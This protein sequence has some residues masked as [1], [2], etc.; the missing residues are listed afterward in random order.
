MGMPVGIK[1]A[2]RW[3]AWCASAMAALAL[4]MGVHKAASGYEDRELPRGLSHPIFA[5]QLA[6]SDA[7]VRLIA[8]CSNA[9][10]RLA[11]CRDEGT[12]RWQ[13]YL[14]FPFVVA[15]T[16]FLLACGW[17]TGALWP[18]LRWIF[19]AGAIVALVAAAMDFR[20]NLAMLWALAGSGA[21]GVRDAGYAKWVWVSGAACF[22]ALAAFAVV[23]GRGFWWR[24][25]SVAV[26]AQILAG[27][28]VVWSASMSGCDLRLEEGA[29]RTMSGLAMLALFV[30]VLVFGAA[31]KRFVIDE[32][33]AR[34]HRAVWG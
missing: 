29:M 32:L 30:L 12:L 33:G 3:L 21:A 15:Y 4:A 8:G 13:V 25:I 2:V 19:W 6:G 18:K 10:E 34:W 31:L 28:V 1:P 27:A 26:A 22:A 24:L 16:G 5:L 11:Q 17:L 7:E 14:D 23:S 9:A 20:E